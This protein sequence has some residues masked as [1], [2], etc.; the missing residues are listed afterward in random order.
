MRRLKR[1]I[2]KG[3]FILIR[4][5]EGMNKQEKQYCSAL[6]HRDQAWSILKGQRDELEK[7]LLHKKASTYDLALLFY[8]SLTVISEIKLFSQNIN[9]IPKEIMDLVKDSSAAG[10]ILRTLKEAKNIKILEDSS[11]PFS[12]KEKALSDLRDSVWGTMCNFYDQISR[13]V[14]HYPLFIDHNDITIF[15]RCLDAALCHM[16]MEDTEVDL[17]FTHH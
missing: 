13:A 14:G 15:Y 2:N 4:N 10:A 3:I 9:N 17:L 11:S 1:S 8:C 16:D 12:D 6:A 7:I 5:I